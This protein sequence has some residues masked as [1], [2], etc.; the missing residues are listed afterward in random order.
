LNKTPAI[1]CNTTKQ[2]L[3]NDVYGILPDDASNIWGSNNMGVFCLFNKKKSD[4]VTSGSLEI[5]Q[6]PI[7]CRTMN[8]IQVLMQL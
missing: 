1:L 6:K 3:P 7:A 2:G 4:A 8:L 5:L